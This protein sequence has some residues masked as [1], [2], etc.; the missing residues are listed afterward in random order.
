MP[1]LYFCYS[2]VGDVWSK[3]P[4]NSPY[5]ITH[6]AGNMLKTLARECGYR[7]EY[8]NLDDATPR[9]LRAGDLAVGHLWHAPGTFMRQ[10]LDSPA[11]TILMQP[12]SHK[13]V[14]QGDIAEY[15]GLFDKADALLFITGRYWYDTL[16]DSPFARIHPKVTRLDMAVN[17]AAH[18]FSKTTWNAKGKRGVLSLGGDLPV[19][20]L[21]HVAELVRAGGYRHRHIG[22]I[23]VDV[24]AHVPQCTVQTGMEFHPAVIREI[25]QESDFF[26]TMGESDANPTTLLEA[27]CWGLIPLCTPQSGYWPNDPFPSLTLGDLPGNLAVLDALQQSDA[28]T[29]KRM[30]AAIREHVIEHHS[31]AQ[32]CETVRGVVSAY[33]D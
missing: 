11:A 31:W 32:F 30:A 12:Y 21:R 27:A 26:V 10:A 18:P 5:S 29:L 20:G 24:F 13:M 6:H 2:A 3:E 28:Y 8:V 9:D 7:Y 22:S 14:S 16:P 1:T 4:L 15:V 17:P 25:C 19:K 23:N 33:L